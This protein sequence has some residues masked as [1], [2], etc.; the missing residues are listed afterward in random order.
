MPN[1]QRMASAKAR[2]GSAYFGNQISW[3]NGRYQIQLIPGAPYRFK[4]TAKADAKK[5][6]LMGRS[7]GKRP[8]GLPNRPPTAMLANKTCTTPM[9]PRR[10]SYPPSPGP[11]DRQTG[12]KSVGTIYVKN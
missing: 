6:T 7:P 5:K 12:P 2:S 10:L 8:S 3:Q 4:S 11:M 1:A 9:K